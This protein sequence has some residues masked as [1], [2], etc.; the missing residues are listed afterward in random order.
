MSEMPLFHVALAL[1]SNLGDRISYLRRAVEALKTYMEV[2]AVSPVYESPAAYVTD[3][4]VF[5]NAALIGATR[6]S[7]LALLWQIKAIENEIGRQPT[8]HYGPRAI[9]VDVIFHGDTVMET[10]E[11]TLPHPRL[12][13]RDFVLQP[14][15]DIAPNWPHPTTG[16]II[17]TLRNA[18]PEGSLRRWA[19]SL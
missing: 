12:A 5:L 8:Y 16:Q 7:P 19:E 2:E 4:P 13:E 1:G 3:Q 9:D 6:L 18:L 14:L 10:P 15:T 11:L 17:Q